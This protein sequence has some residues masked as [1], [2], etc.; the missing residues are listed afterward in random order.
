[1]RSPRF[2]LRSLLWATAII[3]AM[4]AVGRVVIPPLWRVAVAAEENSGAFTTTLGV[5]LAGGVAWLVIL[6]FRSGMY[7]LT[8]PDNDEVDAPPS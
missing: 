6:G 3:A 4:I 1:M 8:K 7:R 5:V 2:T